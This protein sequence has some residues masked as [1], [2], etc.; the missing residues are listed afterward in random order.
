MTCSR[1]G[2]MPATCCLDELGLG[3]CEMPSA[4][5]RQGVSSRRKLQVWERPLGPNPLVLVM[6][7]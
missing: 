7:A 1:V 5:C 2:D 6:L 4:T 3:R